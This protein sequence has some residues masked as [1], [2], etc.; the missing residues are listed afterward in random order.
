MIVPTFFLGKP[1]RGTTNFI[2]SPLCFLRARPEFETEI[3][4][5]R[6]KNVVERKT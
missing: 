3:E 5:P 2:D 6:S 4:D 1:E